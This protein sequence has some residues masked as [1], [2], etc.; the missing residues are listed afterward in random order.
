MVIHSLSFI[1]NIFTT[2]SLYLSKKLHQRVLK[3]VFFDNR[4]ITKTSN[5]NSIPY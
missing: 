3:H 4:V 1:H 5:Y 2:N